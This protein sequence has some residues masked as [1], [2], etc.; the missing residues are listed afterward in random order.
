MAGR[1]NLLLAKLAPALRLP[2]LART[3]SEFASR[4]YPITW[5]SRLFVAICESIDNARAFDMC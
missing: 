4:D 5:M 1:Q 2:D 3:S